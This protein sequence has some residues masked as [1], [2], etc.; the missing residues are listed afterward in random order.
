MIVAGKDKGKT[1]PITNI[2]VENE[3]VVV[4]GLNLRKKTI[5]KKGDKPGTILEVAAPMHIS[6]VMIVDPKGGKPSRISKKKVGDK[7]V[8]VATKSGTVLK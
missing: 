2:I 8:R 7:F 1:G 5:K 3:T 4:E 6:N